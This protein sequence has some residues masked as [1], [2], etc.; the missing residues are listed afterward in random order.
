MNVNNLDGMMLL[1]AIL[2]IMDESKE[3]KKFE[4]TKAS[5]EDVVVEI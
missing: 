4:E 1:N 2:G 3:Y 5:D